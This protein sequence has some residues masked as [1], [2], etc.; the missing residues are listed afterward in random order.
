MWEDV[1]E[2]KCSATYHLL[3][4]SSKWFHHRPIEVAHPI[5]SHQFRVIYITFVSMSTV[6][7]VYQSL[8]L[9]ALTGSN[10]S[11]V[12]LSIVFRLCLKLYM[13]SETSGV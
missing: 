1:H 9:A 4:G 12:C 13:I 8:R 5:T 10:S 7:I 6:E 3:V 2:L 11:Y